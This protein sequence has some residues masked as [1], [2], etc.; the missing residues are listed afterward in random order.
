MPIGRAASA[1]VPD[2]VL[3]RYR[4]DDLDALY[5]ICLK[6]GDAGHDATALY[7]DPKILGHVYAGPYGVLEPE[8]C[9]VLEDGEGVGGYIIGAR[10]TYAFEK[11]MEREWWPDLRA[12]YLEPPDKS[13]PDRHIAHLIHHPER[14]PRFINE[15]YP[16]H[17]H[18]DLLPRFQGKGWGKRMID[19]WLDTMRE[20]NVRGAHLGVG[21][22]N[23]RAVWFYLKY[24]FKE[25]AREGGTLILAITLSSET[26]E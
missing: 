25:I 6:T 15:P 23:A 7:G 16:A 11:R 13:A 5:N 2:I 19:R 17:L 8:S 4:A 10:D 18:I 3:R 22:R 20:R 26:T 12:R 1:C 21:M 14:T 9:F 24:G